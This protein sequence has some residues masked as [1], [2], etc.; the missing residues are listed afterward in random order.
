MAGPLKGSQVEPTSLLAQT[1][2]LLLTSS[3][4]LGKPFNLFGS[5]FPHL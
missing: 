5:Q 4:H 1:L 2:A 3:A